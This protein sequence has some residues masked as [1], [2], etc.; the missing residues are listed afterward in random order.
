M[1][2]KRQETLLNFIIKEYIRTAK[3]VPSM[4]AAGKTKLKVSPATIR[5]EM[6]DLEEQG[7]LVQRHTSGGRVPT[8][9]AYRYYVDRLLEKPGKM[10]ISAQDKKIIASVLAKAGNDSRAINKAMAQVLSERSGNMVIAG[11][12]QEAEFFKQGLVSLLR[13]PE[14]QRAEHLFQL[15]AFFE[16]FDLV[17]QILE[18]EFLNTLGV[19]AG[20]PIQILIGRENPFQ[21]MQG[22][23]MICTKYLLP[24]DNVG[25]LTL[26]GPTRMDYE[27]NIGLIRYAIEI[28]AK[29]TN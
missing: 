24:G 18:R 29:R 11:I 15:A 16:G 10:T 28:L 20:L 26:I 22:E 25:S 4:L 17:F 3:P 9:R 19:P 6:N 5:N 8:D 27:H 7:Y 23:T 13:H 14:F 2:S 1:L 21:H 12:A